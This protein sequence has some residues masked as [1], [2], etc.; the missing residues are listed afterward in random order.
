MVLGVVFLVALLG[1]GCGSK[2]EGKSKG[3]QPGGAVAV[4]TAVV[5]DGRLTGATT[6]SGKLEAVASANVVPKMAGKVAAVAVDVGSTV[7]AGELLVSLDAPELAAAVEL[8]EASLAKAENADLPALQNQTE[9]GVVN[10]RAALES[11]RINFAN[12][13]VDYGRMKELFNAGVIPQQQLEQAEKGFNLAKT[14]YETAQN[15]LQVAENNVNIVNNNTVPETI[16]LFEAQ[17]NQA[18]VNY[19]NSKIT[20]P[21]SGVVTA[22]NINPGEMA[23]PTQPVL[24]IVNLDKLAVQAS[25]SEEQINNLKTGQKVKVK[26]GAVSDELFQGTVANISLAASPVTKAYL[27]KIQVPNA[28][29]V[30]KPGM[31]AEVELPGKVR[32]GVLAPRQALSRNNEVWVVSQGVARKKE[33][34]VGE[35]DGEKVIINTGLTVGEEVVTSGQE[36]LTDGVSVSVKN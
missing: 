3:D 18:R 8:A 34:T 25:V 36:F 5:E 7:R 28:K 29:H 35:S 33:V 11:A 23:A 24:T 32:E 9:A 1:A 17:L 27:V 21:I 10:A 22:R 15:N 6:V 12:A 13:G 16:R 30:L 2:G 20:A 19:A 31:F 14:A 4:T 26:I